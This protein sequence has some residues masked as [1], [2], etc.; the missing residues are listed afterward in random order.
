MIE[1]KNEGLA[2]EPREHEWVG[3][4]DGVKAFHIVYYELA[5]PPY[6]AEGPVYAAKPDPHYGVYFWPEGW[7]SFGQACRSDHTRNR[8]YTEEEAKKVAEEHLTRFGVHPGSY[9]KL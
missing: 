5:P 3:Y 8:V 2:G 6:G 7:N 1:W 4:V 9:S